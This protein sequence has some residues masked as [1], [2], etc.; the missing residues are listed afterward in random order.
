MS[1]FRQSRP[2]TKKCH[3]IF[4]IILI[5]AIC[6]E[7]LTPEIAWSVSPD[8]SLYSD[9]L[10]IRN[11]AYAIKEKL[12]K[13]R[14]AAEKDENEKKNLLLQLR[15]LN[16][17]YE[18]KTLPLSKPKS[19][20]EISPTP[21]SWESFELFLDKY[22]SITNEKK[23]STENLEIT[24]KQQQEFYTKLLALA[25]DDPEQHILQLQHA[26]QARKS[27]YQL[28]IDN[29][30][31][32]NLKTFKK[33]FPQ[34]VKQLNISKQS[35]AEQKS[36]L[37][38]A[39]K[40]IHKI[41]EEKTLAIAA[42]DVL[43][44]EQESTL[45]GYLG[46]DLD[47]SGKKKM[48]YN[49]LKLLEL[50]VRKLVITSQ[51]LDS[52]INVYEAEQHLFWFLLLGPKQNYFK[53]VDSSGD[54]NQNIDRLRKKTNALRRHLHDYETQ[55]STL[56]GGNALIGPK[57]EELIEIL[58]NDIQIAGTQLSA[59]RKCV[60]TIQRKGHLLEKAIHFKQSSLTSMIIKTREATGDIAE[61]IMGIMTYPL[62]SY[63]GMTLSLLLITE[64]FILLLLAIIINRLYGCFIVRIG[65]QR[66]WSE[67][68]VHL[69]QA[70][71]KYPF[72]FIV[73]MVM[74]SV[75][76][77]NTSSLALVAGALSVGI[78]FGMQTIANN[79]VSG[80]I[81]LFDKSIRPGDFISLGD[82]SETG[83]FRGN[84]VQMNTRATVLR[85]NDNINIII[86]NADLIAS[87]VVNWTYGD[88]KIRFRIPFSVAYG[89]DI[90]KVKAV[91][92]KSLLDLPAVLSHPSPQIWMTEHGNSSLN[93]VAAI[94]V[95][96]PHSRQPARTSD[97]VLTKIYTT[98][99]Q[100][101]IDIPF[102]QM[103][104]RI[105]RNEMKQS[106]ETTT[107]IE[108]LHQKIRREYCT[109]HA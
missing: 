78:G 81:L 7:I 15:F 65:V 47:D 42:N 37:L 77:V 1:I 44:E 62:L 101:N 96:S 79:L 98:L 13:T 34:L 94:W 91:I 28:G 9:Q 31:N 10:E 82:G 68:T 105:R 76:G 16:K 45:A 63:N 97:S 92:K 35:I 48:H 49:Q 104:L 93:F 27:T 108:M 59:I 51:L 109:Q 66:N 40:T 3:F 99:D 25:E 29:N 18:I 50:L 87:K 102:P 71:G 80:I 95:Q 72:I 74:L 55:L 84:V 88:D 8:T 86:P 89:T 83:G 17:L 41:E 11:T 54:M 39:K 12:L 23:Q 56:R 4:V 64:I 20:Y 43:I 75:I 2:Q 106:D 36:N 46:Q 69:I 6:T 73:A 24:I 70:T 52:Q 100:H 21:P 90:D 61:N 53:L 33:Y 14:I 32:T 67:R 85:T 60:D 58:E 19:N 57:S 22:I 5:S 103:D 26:Y 30:L 107:I 38:K